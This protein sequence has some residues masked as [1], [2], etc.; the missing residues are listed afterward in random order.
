M[1]AVGALSLNIGNCAPSAHRKV[2]P[3]SSLTELK[4]SNM[5]GTVYIYALLSTV[6]TKYSSVS[7]YNQPFFKTMH[8]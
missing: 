1:K 2:H 6:S 7:H 8:I 4:E 5:K 3:V